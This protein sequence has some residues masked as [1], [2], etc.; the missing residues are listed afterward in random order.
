MPG[1]ISAVDRV[2]RLS[3]LTLDYHTDVVLAFRRYACD[4]L[5]DMDPDMIEGLIRQLVADIDY[6]KHDTV[7]RA[8]ARLYHDEHIDAAIRSDIVNIAFVVSYHSTGNR[9]KEER[10]YWDDWPMTLIENRKEPTRPFTYDIPGNRVF[11]IR[12]GCYVG[13]E[14]I[15]HDDECIRLHS[16]QAIETCYLKEKMAIINEFCDSVG[17]KE[18][19]EQEFILDIDLDYFRTARAI[20]PADSAEFYKLIRQAVAITIAIEPACVEARKL[21]GEDITADYLLSRLEHHIAEALGQ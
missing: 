13:C 12:S 4:A 18:I 8:V 3:L 16:D 7:S 15:C 5:D 11:E 19:I 6:T 1:L 10:E 2:A 14:K 17:L 9:S 21:S 20:E